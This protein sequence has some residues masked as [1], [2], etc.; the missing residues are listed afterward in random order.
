MLKKDADTKEVLKGALYGL[1]A[2]EDF[3]TAI[4]YHVEDDRWMNRKE[5]EL[6]VKKDTLLAI[7]ATQADGRA[8]FMEDLPLGNYYV[9][10]LEAP[11]GYLLSEEMKFIDGTYHSIKGGQLVE[12]QVHLI[13][14][15]NKKIEGYAPKP[16]GPKPEKPSEPEEPELV[17]IA[18]V[19]KTIIP[20]PVSTGDHANLLLWLGC[21][22]AMLEFLWLLWNRKKKS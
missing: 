15:E 2:A 8:V 1:Y 3:Y 19:P 18:E 10:E 21:G 16:E 6:A 14:F 12:K 11:E 7:A 22:L 20:E 9:K 5:P 13:D 4:Q 17:E